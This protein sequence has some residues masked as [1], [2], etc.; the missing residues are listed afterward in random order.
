MLYYFIASNETTI[1]S[2]IIGAI[3]EDSVDYSSLLR[4]LYGPMN[5]R[6][7]KLPFIDYLHEPCKDDPRIKELWKIN[8]KG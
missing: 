1:H 8:R 7:I 5:F 2:F 3:E 4:E 6:R